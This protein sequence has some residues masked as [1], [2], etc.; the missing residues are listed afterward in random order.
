MFDRSAFIFFLRPLTTP[1]PCFSLYQTNYAASLLLPIPNSLSSLL[2]L[3]PN[4]LNAPV[5]AM[6]PTNPL[7]PLLSLTIFTRR[8][9]NLEC[10]LCL[11]FLRPDGLLLGPFLYCDE[12]GILLSTLGPAFF[13]TFPSAIKVDLDLIAITS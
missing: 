8:F 9:S 3:T 6:F 10:G 2:L 4:S 7:T 13:H 12:C 5:A 1:P 11:Q